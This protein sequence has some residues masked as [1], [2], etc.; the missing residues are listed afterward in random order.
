MYYVY[1]LQH[2]LTKEKYI[3]CTSELSNRVM[4][5]NNNQ[6]T[7]TMRDQGYWELKYYEAYI[8]KDDAFQREKRLKQHGR[9]KQE[10]YKRCLNSLKNESGAG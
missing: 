1:L 10:L 5:H 2:S 9:A 7:S 4:Q 8:S 3:G 6:N